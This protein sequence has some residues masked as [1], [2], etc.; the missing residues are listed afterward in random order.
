MLPCD[1]NTGSP[2][3]DS[4]DFS[5][6][7]SLGHNQA[8]N[9]NYWHEHQMLRS[10]A[11]GR[12]KSVPFALNPSGHAGMAAAP[13]DTGAAHEPHKVNTCCLERAGG[14]DQGRG[15]PPTKSG[16]GAL[17]P[18]ATGSI[19]QTTKYNETMKDS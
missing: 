7:A 10:H 6:Y 9:Y 8:A 18:S 11:H 4:A 1:T 12:E 14:E 13:P 2:A 3:A 15:N 16:S 17:P 5:L 19:Q